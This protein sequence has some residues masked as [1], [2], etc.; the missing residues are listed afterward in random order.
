MSQHRRAPRKPK[1]TL[2]QRE[3]KAFGAV[4]VAK[5]LSG[6]TRKMESIG[7][8]CKLN[9]RKQPNIERHEVPK[10]QQ[11][12]ET[13]VPTSEHGLA[14]L[15]SNT[16]SKTAKSCLKPVVQWNA[17]NVRPK[18]FQGSYSGKVEGWIMIKKQV[19]SA[20]KVQ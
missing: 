6:Q 11:P 17:V 13:F 7:D 15:I 5:K 12:S 4:E 2:Q 3:C 16:L 20:S 9:E 1:L 14:K 19:T 10:E 8:L 18:V